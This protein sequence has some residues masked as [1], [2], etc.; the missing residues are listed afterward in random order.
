MKKRVEGWRRTVA[1]AIGCEAKQLYFTSCGTESDNW[2][3]QA[4]LWQNRHLGKHI[5]TTSVEHSAVLETCKWWEKQGYEVTYVKP[6]STG[7]I[8]AEQV[9]EAVRPDTALVSVMLVNNELGTIYPVADIA[10]GLAVKN[11]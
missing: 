11:P 2:A 4:A 6:D 3:I 10:Q 9:L 8:T 7:A 5:V 1:D